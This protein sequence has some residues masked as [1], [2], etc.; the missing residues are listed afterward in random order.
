MISLRRF[1]HSPGVR[2]T[3]SDAYE[4]ESPQSTQESLGNR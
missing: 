4:L 2:I 1:L 3:G